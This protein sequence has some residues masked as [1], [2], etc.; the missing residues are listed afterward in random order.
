MRPA[1]NTGDMERLRRVG[2]LV[3]LLLALLVHIVVFVVE[4][5]GSI[6]TLLLSGM[7]IVLG[8]VALLLYSLQRITPALLSRLLLWFAVSWNVLSMLTGSLQSQ[9]LQPTIYLS[10]LVLVVMVFALLPLRLAAGLSMGSLLLLVLLAVTRNSVDWVLLSATAFTGF[11]SS[12]MMIFGQGRLVQDEVQQ[13]AALDPV[14]GLLTRQAGLERLRAIHRRGH[15]PSGSAPDQTP[16][17]GGIMLLEPAAGHLDEQYYGPGV[18]SEVLRGLGSRLRQWL[19]EPDFACRWEGQA[20]MVVWHT[21]PPPQLGTPLSEVPF[22]DGVLPVKLHR[23]LAFI[24]ESPD[25]QGVIALAEVRLEQQR[26]GPVL[27]SQ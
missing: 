16:G 18:R 3:I 4:R 13:V 8:L 5:Q 25:L 9:L 15:W 26:A 22:R 17:W 23:G 7:G 2:L 24:H 12:Y 14:T 19:T 6:L 11:M 27:P 10:H 21:A 20:L 1:L